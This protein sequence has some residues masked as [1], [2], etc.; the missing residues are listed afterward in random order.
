MF[1]VYLK[2]YYNLYVIVIANY[3]FCRVGPRLRP[4]NSF[5][6]VMSAVDLN[7][8]L[9]S[10]RA[11]NAHLQ[12]RPDLP[13]VNLGLDQVEV[14][15]RRLV[16]RYGSSTTMDAGRGYYSLLLSYWIINQIIYRNFLLAQA[17]VDAP[18]LVNSIATLNTSS[19]FT[20]LR[21]LLDTD[22]SGYLRH[23]HEQTLIS[24]I[25]EGRRETESEF[26]QVLDERIRKQW[27]SR[28]KRIFEELGRHAFTESSPFTTADLRGPAS[29]S[30]SV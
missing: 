9:T 16:G 27:E 5:F 6:G 18:S 15:S 14:Q 12:T 2:Y 20:P 3:S 11:L 28:K 30:S 29:L 1:L 23:A 17:N 24:T 13:T 21:P 7:S 19:T 22:V 10:S 8:I 26:Y 25:E 4:N